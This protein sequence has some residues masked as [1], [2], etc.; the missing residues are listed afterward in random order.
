MRSIIKLGPDD[1]SPKCSVCVY[2][3]P[4]VGLTELTCAKKGVVAPD[5]ICKKFSLDIM[6][7]TARRKHS[8]GTKEL[9]AEDFSI[10]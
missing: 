3:N 10:D 6:A 5:H 8:L 7:K 4:L 9:S 2:S 1:Q